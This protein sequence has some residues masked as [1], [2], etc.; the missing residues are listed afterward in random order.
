MTI[1]KAPRVAPALICLPSA[2]DV[3]DATDAE[4]LV[5]VVAVALVVPALEPEEDRIDV[6]RV[7]TAD[8]MDLTLEVA[9]APEFADIRVDVEVAEVVPPPLLAAV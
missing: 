5:I 9:A 7:D 8:S 2:E 1:P 4:V 6:D 3:V